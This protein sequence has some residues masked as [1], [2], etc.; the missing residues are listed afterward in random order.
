MAN[1]LDLSKY[2]PL[3]EAT[4]YIL[5]SLIRPLHGYGIMQD[6][7]ALS[8]GRMILG[9]GTLYGALSKLEKEGLVQQTEVADE[10]DSRR[11]YYILT[12]YGQM[13]AKLEYERLIQLIGDGRKQLVQIGVITDD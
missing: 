7:E 3:T 2:L 12:K 13:V 5:I 10:G 9:P 6:V 8:K 4:Y 11:K 1:N